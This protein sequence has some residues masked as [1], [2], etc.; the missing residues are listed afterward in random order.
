M[1]QPESVSVC[2]AT[3]N[4]ARFL[5]EQLTSILDEL[6]DGDEVVVVDDAS[7]DGT[8]AIL[9]SFDDR[10][11]RVI[12]QQKNAGYVATFEHAMRSASGEVLFLADQDD[13]W[14]P[15]RREALIA[16]LSQS[17][18]VAS[19][20]LLLGSNE[21]LPS[22]ITG[23]PWRLSRATSHQYVRNR[24]RILLGI[25][26]YYGCAMAIRRD[27]TRVALPFPSFLV[28]SHDLWLAI[29][30]NR[31]HAMSHVMAPTILRRIHDTNSS[32]SKPRGAIAVIRSRWML[33]RAIR[34]ADRRLRAQAKM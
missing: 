12:R 2:M 33:L 3:Y 15:G 26:P 18:V 11:I 10:R 25:A 8:V 9:E 29:L 20:L 13:V 19:N 31:A 28:E 21:A 30:A 34:E 4:G 32:P 17:Q 7:D 5:S 24:V 6:Q 1:P 14:I 27:F 23:R 16:G 22:P